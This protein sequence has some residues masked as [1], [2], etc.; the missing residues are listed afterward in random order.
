MKNS[1]FT[2][3]QISENKNNAT[4]IISN[5]DEKEYKKQT[6][7]QPKKIRTIKL[8]FLDGF[9]FGFGF[10]VAVVFFN[11]IVLLLF[12]LLFSSFISLPTSSFLLNYY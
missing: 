10:I 8:T 11:I 7:N 4:E 12:F 6:I 1:N 3:K 9:N 5:K 2:E